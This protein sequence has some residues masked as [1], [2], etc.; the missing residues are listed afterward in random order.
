MFL[1]CS[2]CQEAV[3]TR[4]TA[5]T[6][7]V[8]YKGGSEEVRGEQSLDVTRGASL[9]FAKCWGRARAFTPHGKHI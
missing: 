3:V 1:K 6:K 2:C 7:G 5:V 9:I 8:V 4:R